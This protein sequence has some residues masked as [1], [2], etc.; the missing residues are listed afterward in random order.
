MEASGKTSLLSRDLRNVLKEV[1]GKGT[2][3]EL[4]KRLDRP[5]PKLLEV[6]KQLVKEGFIREF[7]TAPQTIAPPSQSMVG[8]DD[9]LDF[10]AAPPKPATQSAPAKNLDAERQSREAEQIALTAAATRAREQVAA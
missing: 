5:E 8:S 4:Q 3:G 1:D 10:T 6:L 9:D 2:V 7:V